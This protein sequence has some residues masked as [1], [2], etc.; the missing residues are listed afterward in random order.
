MDSFCHPAARSADVHA[1]HAA[2]PIAPVTVPGHPWSANVT[3]DLATWTVTCGHHA[4]FAAGT[5][6]QVEDAW[7]AHVH[8]ATGTAPAAMGDLTKDRWTP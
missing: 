2:T 1:M 6:E 5:Y 3:A 7:R 8:G 4:Q